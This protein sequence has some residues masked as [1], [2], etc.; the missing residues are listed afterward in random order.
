[1]LGK[2]AASR[3]ELLLAFGQDC[4]GAVSVMDPEP[5]KL[6][7]DLMDLSDPKQAAALTGRASLSGVQAK[8]AAVLRNG[9][10]SPAQVGELSTHIIKFPSHK[11][12]DLVMNEFLTTQ[13]VKALL[14]DDDVVDLKIGEVSGVSEPVLI[15]KRFDRDVNKQRIH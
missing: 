15:I 13:A 12:H 5:S 8:L 3:F 1:L 14:P 9:K 11:H 10:I 2:R 4:A 7:D 6:S